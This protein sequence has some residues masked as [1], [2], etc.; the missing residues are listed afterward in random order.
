MLLQASMR[1]APLRRGSYDRG[2]RRPDSPT[3]ANLRSRL[4]SLIIELAGGVPQERIAGL[5]SLVDAGEFTVELENLAGN[6]YDVDGAVPEPLLAELREL[7]GMLRAH[8]PFH[9][10]GPSGDAG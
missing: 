3:T 4:T 2:V 5:H 6:L 9:L 7:A 1:K 10:L 8:G